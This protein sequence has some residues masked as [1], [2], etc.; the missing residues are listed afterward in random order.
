MNSSNYLLDTSILVDTPLQVF[1]PLSQILWENLLFICVTV[2]LLLMAIAFFY[3]LKRKKHT[4]ESEEMVVKIDPYE[5]AKKELRL[6]SQQSPQIAPK[7]YIFALSKI[8]RL[9]IE[10]QFK[11][12]A[13]EQTSEEFITSVS[14]H[15]FLSL[16]CLQSI[17]K[18][19]RLGDLIKYAP[20]NSVKD[21][22]STLFELAERII[23]L[24]HQELEKKKR[25]E[26]QANK[27]APKT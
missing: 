17:E 2:L 24:A 26:V 20:L 19:A 12:S 21:E 14:N 22:M 5:E 16:H 3:W 10:R 6:L 23:D 1:K 4:V 15:S 9:Y 25:I 18:F 11:L 8:L 27:E 13:M 7:P